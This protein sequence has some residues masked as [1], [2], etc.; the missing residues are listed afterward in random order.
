M[1]IS[2]QNYLNGLLSYELD[3]E[4]FALSDGRLEKQNICFHR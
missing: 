1:N 4:M 2:L 3:T